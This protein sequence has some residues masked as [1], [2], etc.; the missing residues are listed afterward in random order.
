M[1]KISAGVDPPSVQRRDRA[2]RRPSIPRVWCSPPPSPTAC[3]C[4]SPWF[5]P[6]ISPQMGPR[7]RANDCACW[8]ISE[9]PLEPFL[10]IFKAFRSIYLNAIDQWRTTVWRTS[11]PPF[12]K[13]ERNRS[14]YPIG[15]LVPTTGPTV[16]VERKWY[17]DMA[18]EMTPRL[19]SRETLVE[20][21]SVS[22]S[23]P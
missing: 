9:S 15:M 8:R 7:L 2:C 14:T 23:R 6:Q 1:T 4:P 5:G 22:G 17:P 13:N 3:A 21:G 12:Q 11:P 16:K 18:F 19:P 10:Q 20:T